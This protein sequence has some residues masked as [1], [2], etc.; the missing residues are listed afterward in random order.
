MDIDSALTVFAG[1]QEQLEALKEVRDKD[2]GGEWS[3]FVKVHVVLDG[4][5]E[6]SLP[7]VIEGRWPNVWITAEDEDGMI[8]DSVLRDDE[9]V[10]QAYEI[11]RFF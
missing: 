5:A 10:R 4:L 7:Q 1:I 9:V 8:P 3:K 6:H 11:G 2:S